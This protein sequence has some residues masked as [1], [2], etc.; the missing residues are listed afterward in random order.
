MGHKNAS[1]NATAAALRKQVEDLAQQAQELQTTCE[2][3]QKAYFD[4]SKETSRRNESHTQDMEALAAEAMQAIDRAKL[5]AFKEAFTILAN[6]RAS[7]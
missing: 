5:E 2:Y 4:V 7:L 3:W 6:S 1:C